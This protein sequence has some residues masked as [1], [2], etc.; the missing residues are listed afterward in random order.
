MHLEEVQTTIKDTELLNKRR[1]S[2]CKAAAKEFLKKGYERT[3]I[4]DIAEAAKLSVGSIYRYVGKKE[5]IF[6]LLLQYIWKIVDDELVPLSFLD[7]PPVEKLE[8]LFDKYCRMIDEYRRYFVVT[9]RDNRSMDDAQRAVLWEMENTIIGCFSRVIDEGISNG[10][11]KESLDSFFSY[12]LLILGQQW[13]MRNYHYKGIV[14]DEFID[15][16]MKIINS[17]CVK[18]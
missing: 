11:F 10:T 8:I 12:N 15:K 2:L 13:T 6:T 3:T 1:A 16:Q 4:Q 14:L 18:K 17:I 7:L 5:D 9:I